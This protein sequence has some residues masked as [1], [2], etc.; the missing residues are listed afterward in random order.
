M[1][2]EKKKNTEAEHPN[3]ISTVECLN[4]VRK[5]RPTTTTTPTFNENVQCEIKPLHFSNWEL[6]EMGAKARNP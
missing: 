1:K 3:D 6:K 5:G 4:D 2:I